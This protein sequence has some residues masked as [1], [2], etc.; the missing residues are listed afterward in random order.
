MRVEQP[1]NYQRSSHLASWKPR[2]SSITQQLRQGARKGRYL[3]SHRTPSNRSTLDFIRAS[4]NSYRP[5]SSRLTSNIWIEP[6]MAASLHERMMKKTII[7]VIRAEGW[8]C[9]ARYV[10]RSKG[11]NGEPCNTRRTP[12]STGSGGASQTRLSLGSILQCQSSRVHRTSKC[13]S[14]LSAWS[15]TR[16]LWSSMSHKKMVRTWKR[17]KAL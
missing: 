13:L 9:P 10:W 11:K 8:R 6:V 12:P 5:T 2:S 4:G 1:L 3:T 17:I 15:E 14:C 16:L 7:W